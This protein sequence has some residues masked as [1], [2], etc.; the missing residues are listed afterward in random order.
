MRKMD[1]MEQAQAL[2]VIRVT[3]FYSLIFETAYWIFQCVQVKAFLTTE[4]ILFFLIVTQGLVLALS[5]L[6]FKHKMGATKS[7]IGLFSAL[8]F[9]AFF[10]I[11][12]IFLVKIGG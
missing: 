7:K 2:Q 1:E 5:Q 4:S 3:F 9:A 11:I 10:L 12:G 8:A 6:I